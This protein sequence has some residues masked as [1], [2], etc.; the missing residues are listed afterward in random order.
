MTDPTRRQFVRLTSASIIS[1]GLLGTASCAGG[2]GGSGPGSGNQL[3]MTWWGDPTRG[4]RMQQAID[5]FTQA[6][7]DISVTAQ[8]AGWEGYWDKLATQMAGGNAADWIMMDQS[9]LADYAEREALADLEPLVGSQLDLSSVPTDLVD[10]ARVGGSLFVVPLAVNTQALLYNASV[11]ERS[12]VAAPGGEMTWEQFADLA[13]QVAGSSGG[14]AGSADRGGYIDAFE[15][16]LRGQGGELYREEGQE[17]AVTADDVRQWWTFW[18][19]LRQAGALVAPDVQAAADAGG[20]RANPVV[21]GEAA[22]TFDWSPQWTNFQGMTEDT[23]SGHALPV[24]DARPGQFVKAANYFCSPSRSDSTEAAAEL[25]SFLIN[26]QDA[27]RAL[28]LTLG[29]PASTAMQEAIAGDLDDTER[30]I[31]AYVEEVQ[32]RSTPQQRPWVRGHGDLGNALSRH[33]QDLSFGR[34]SVDEASALFI[35]DAERAISG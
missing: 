4:E 15:V 24:G 13:A 17:L 26:D 9:Y 22:M 20:A 10:S 16:W 14:A 12:G 2:S 8:P 25:A 3:Q 35:D 11:F 19:G 6:N 30:Q 28:G 33:Y 29:V 18:D 21:T 23:I 7:S 32:G 27:A 1:L 34:V 5:M 31:V